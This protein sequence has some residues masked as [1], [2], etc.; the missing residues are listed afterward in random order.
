[1]PVVIGIFIFL[2]LFTSFCLW[3]IGMLF[4]AVVS[5]ILRRVPTRR[6]VFKLFGTA[7]AGLFVLFIAVILNT[8]TTTSLKNT[9]V[10]E[11]PTTSPQTTKTTDT[12]T[13]PTSATKQAVTS[14][15]PA[16]T[17]PTVT[18]FKDGDYVVGTDIQPGT[19]RTRQGSSG[20][21][22]SRL[23][24]FSGSLSDIISNENTDAPAV[25]SIAAADKG[26]K[27][28]RCGTWTKDLSAITTSKTSF[29]DGIFIVNTDITAGTYRSTGGNGCYYSRLKGFGGTLS[30]IISN[31]NTDTSAIIT[32]AATDKG[33][34]SVRCGTWSKI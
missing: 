25:I 26:F 18:Q 14:Q 3:V 15:V 20:C 32:I 16:E 13:Q 17:K 10:S 8:D 30:D 31:E 6:Q 11:L 1:M 27:S 2:L 28:V 22:Y 5:P 9:N 19:Y 7:T 24:G 33:F 21:Y 34:K 4:P 29:S 23:S 12:S